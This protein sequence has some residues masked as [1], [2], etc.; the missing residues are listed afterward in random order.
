MQFTAEDGRRELERVAAFA[1][2]YQ[3]VVALAREEL[4]DAVERLW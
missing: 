2:G 1:A 3:S 4:A